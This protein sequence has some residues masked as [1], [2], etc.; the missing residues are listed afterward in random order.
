MRSG[1]SG[2]H[3]LLKLC[4]AGLSRSCLGLQLGISLDKSIAQL[5]SQ[6]EIT[7]LFCEQEATMQR[8]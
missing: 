4:H 3:L 6:G 2:P 8:G 7:V 5:A 1:P